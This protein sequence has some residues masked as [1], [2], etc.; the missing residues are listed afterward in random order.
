M[1]GQQ[2]TVQYIGSG[3][4]M[5]MSPHMT[6]GEASSYL[7]LSV[8]TLERYRQFLSGPRF[9]R[10]GRRVYYEKNDLDRWRQDNKTIQ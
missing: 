8:R 2:A 1:A 9:M 7:R 4:M 10:L 5:D 3:L 6:T